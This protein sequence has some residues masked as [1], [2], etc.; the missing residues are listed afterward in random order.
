FTVPAD[1]TINCEQDPNDLTLTGDV[2][3]EAD[4]CDNT[5]ETTFTDST[6]NGTCANESVITRT[7]TLT[8]D[9]NNTTTLVQTIT[10]Q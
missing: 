4:N 8:D 7:W 2:T 10:I 1:I 9:C 3:N 5:L 6:A